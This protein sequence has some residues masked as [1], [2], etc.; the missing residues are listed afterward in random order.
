MTVG[1]TAGETRG[2]P[3]GGVTDPAG[4]GTYSVVFTGDLSKCALSATIT[5]ATPGEITVTP[6][7][8]ADK[9]TTTVEVRT[10]NSAGTAAD[11]PLH[12]GANC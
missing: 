1:G 6:T 10:F 9:K 5:G 11:R 8:A 2:V 4:D 3:T 7:V 12:L